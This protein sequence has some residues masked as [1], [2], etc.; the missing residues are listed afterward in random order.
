M[1]NMGLNYFIQM[2]D[3]YNDKANP[4]QKK[5]LKDIIELI[6]NEEKIAEELEKIEE[7]LLGETL[8]QIHDTYKGYPF[9]EEEIEKAEK[10]LFK[11]IN[12]QIL[13][14]KRE[15]IK[16]LIG[17][18]AGRALERNSGMGHLL[19]ITSIRDAFGKE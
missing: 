9:Y 16:N 2:I 18:S 13:S 17:A 15:T 10:T 19:Y 4:K 6:G 11:D 1:C 8:S 12:Y 14:I 7:K 5:Q 3:F